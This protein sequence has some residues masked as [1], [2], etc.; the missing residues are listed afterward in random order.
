MKTI[1]GDQFSFF[2]NGTDAPGQQ[3]GEAINAPSSL[4]NAVQ[5]GALPGATLPVGP[6]APQAPGVTAS[7]G[8][9]PQSFAFLGADV[10]HQQAEQSFPPSLIAATAGTNAT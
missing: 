7:P 5:P 3:P 1:F 8:A 4:D 10:S 2:E 9:I 6:P